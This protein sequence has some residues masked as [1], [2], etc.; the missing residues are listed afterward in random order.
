MNSEQPTQTALANALG[1]A[2]SRITAMKKEGMPT[3]SIEAAHAWRKARQNIARRKPMPRQQKPAEPMAEHPQKVTE[4]LMAAEASLDAGQSIS[5]LVPMLRAAMAAV[6]PAQRDD[7]GLPLNVF[8]LLVAHVLDALPPREEN[9]LDDDGEPIW[10]DGAAMSHDEAQV[11][12]EIW[13]EI[14]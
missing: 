10:C 13:Y 2:R 12:G 1:L 14:A 6:P 11:A 4:M 3:H 7:V 5:A 8:R 9:P